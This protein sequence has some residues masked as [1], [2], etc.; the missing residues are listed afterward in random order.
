MHDGGPGTRC[1][2]TLAGGFLFTLIGVFTG[3]AVESFPSGGQRLDVFAALTDGVGD[4][5][6]D[7]VVTQLDGDRQI[8]AQSMEAWS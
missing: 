7:L 1:L 4:G 6:V 3:V 5:A 8:N 2:A